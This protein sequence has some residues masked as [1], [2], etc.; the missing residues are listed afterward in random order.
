MEAWGGE[1]FGS[2]T[3]SLGKGWGQEAK[4]QPY[5]GG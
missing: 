2:R 3:V 1:R 5:R 4:S